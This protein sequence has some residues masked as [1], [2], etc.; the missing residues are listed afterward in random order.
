MGC[1]RSLGVLMLMSI[2]AFPA[3]SSLTLASQGDPTTAEL[4]EKIR[5]IQSELAR[6]RATDAATGENRIS[7]LERQVEVLAREIENLKLGEAA[8][9]ADKGK[10]GLAPAA[11]KV[12]RT[13]RGVSIGG[14][15]EMLYENF[16]SSRED[17]SP[18]GKKDQ[19]DFLR[20]IVYFGYKF[21]D[22]I[23]FNSEIEFEHASTGKTGEVSV[24]FAYLDFLI[25]E[26][27]NVRTGMLLV[28]M[29]FVNELHEPPTFLGAKRPAV[30]QVIIPTTWRE[31]GAGVFG[32]V[33]PVSYRAYV[34]TGLAG[35]P[36]TSSRAG[37]FS[38]SG[39][40]GGRSS[41]SR[42]A[43]EDFAVVG[44]ID[45]KPIEILTFGASAYTGGAGQGVV[46]PD[47]SPVDS[48]VTILEGHAELR[49]RG[50]QARAL[51]AKT[52]IDDVVNLNAAITAVNGDFDGLS[53]GEKQYGWYGEIGYDVLSHVDG[54]RHALIPYVRYERYNTQDRVPEGFVAE[55]VHDVT[56]ATAGLAW[57]PIPNVV[58]KADWNVVENAARTGVD[59]ANVA[60][61][62][63][64]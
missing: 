20:A 35:V 48:T 30:E 8:V 28:P 62:Y 10:Y 3:P 11:S 38:E 42:S 19:L 33:G 14:Y 4:E 25:R 34:V 27:F 6:L 43:A 12:Y 39:I 56:I 15:G 59:Q 60:V 22:S 16:S 53:V 50:L 46:A 55:P 57:K 58:V 45:W 31:N 52:D 54:T 5:E 51:Y 1:T 61:G 7:E 37:G 40:R 9:E 13:K 26:G 64:F 29:G 32:E 23:V 21:N 49:W 24:E 36:G 17:G 47:G 2:L 63:L 41:G 18:S 44:R